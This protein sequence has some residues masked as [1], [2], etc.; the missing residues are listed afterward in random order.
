MS[1]TAVKRS[2]GRATGG[3]S[4][5]GDGAPRIARRPAQPS[6]TA[7]PTVASRATKPASPSKGTTRRDAV[8]AAA[9][10]RRR[11]LVAGGL[12]A[13][14]TI[15]S[16]LLLVLQPAPLAPDAVRS[17]MSLTAPDDIKELLQ[18]RVPLAP[19]RWKFVYVHHS[20]SV[21]GSAASVA[22]TGEAG[23]AA[24]ALADHFVIGNG[25]GAG[26][27]E[28]QVGQ[29]WNAQE[30]AGRTH[31]LDRVDPDCI[32]VCLIGD[33]DRAPPTPRQMDQLGRL[34]TSL[35][36]KFQIGRERIWVVDAPR[37]PAGCGRYFPREAFRGGLLP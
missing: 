7:R 19:N 4:R 21:E 20:G 10:H 26:D 31:G 27:G 9:G 30:S 18:T 34:I 8:A 1:A 14:L 25:D 5:V 28:V 32:S 11:V 15:T 2:A 24:A 16:A 13:T 29:R 22:E 6:A 36:S 33:L 23:S 12:V 17:L 35:Q 37:L 3:T